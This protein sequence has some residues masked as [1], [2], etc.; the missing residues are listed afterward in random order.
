MF[1][2]L[3]TMIL[4]VRGDSICSNNRYISKAKELVVQVGK[5]RKAVVNFSN[6][7]LPDASLG[8]PQMIKINLWYNLEEQCMIGGCGHYV[9]TLFCV[10]SNN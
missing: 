3:V 9:P 2:K 7:R 10:L 1:T 6:A 4:Y 5:F 8:W